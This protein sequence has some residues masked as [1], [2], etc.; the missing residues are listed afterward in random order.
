MSH[1]VVRESV[2]CQDIASACKECTILGQ[3]ASRLQA[4]VL[5][6][7]VHQAS[8]RGP[9]EQCKIRFWKISALLRVVV[10]DNK[11]VSSGDHYDKC[12]E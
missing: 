8:K 7:Q 5:C 11:P 10:F 9:R 6:R 1:D 12:G 4:I 2:S 3:K